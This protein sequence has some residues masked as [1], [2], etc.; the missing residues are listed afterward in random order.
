M[1]RG[2]VGRVHNSVRGDLPALP[3]PRDHQAKVT[4]LADEAVMERF[5]R[6]A[7]GLRPSNLEK[8]DNVITIFDT[9][10]YDYWSGGGVTAKALASQLKAISGPVEV[11]INSP[12]G[13]V[14]EGFAIYNLLRDHAHKVTVKVL[15][16]AASAASI[17]AM[18]GD[19]VL[20]GKSA[21]VMIHNSWV[22]AIGNRNDLAETAAWLKPFDEALRDVYVARTGISADKIASYMDDETYFNGEQAVEL[23]FADGY[24]PADQITMDPE[25][26]A[27]AHEQNAIRATENILLASGMSRSQARERIKEIK[28][29]TQ[30]AA[31]PDDKPDAVA[32]PKVVSGAQALFGKRN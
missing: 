11:Q 21:F 31:K 9:I 8:D 20:V 6:D 7:A 23:G 15:G 1:P 2:V 32:K 27:N 5:D 17:I 26:R 28:G 24:L 13:D 22:L 30:D 18:A 14:F 12:G 16:M 19:E 4:A 25:A 29:R 10:G 3:I